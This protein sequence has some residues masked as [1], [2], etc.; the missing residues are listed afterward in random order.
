M[1]SIE[2]QTEQPWRP[3]QLQEYLAMLLNL[4]TRSE[5]PAFA[6]F[7][8]TAEHD[9]IFDHSRVRTTDAKI[10]YYQA[11]SQKSQK[12]VAY[13]GWKPLDADH[14]ELLRV[15]TALIYYTD[16]GGSCDAH[17]QAPW[18]NWNTDIKDIQHVCERHLLSLM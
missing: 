1:A 12:Q 7:A 11:L 16:L 18:K 15:N 17:S 6:Y 14:L 3:G 2:L 13:R 8:V 9:G 4:Y 10:L 5:S